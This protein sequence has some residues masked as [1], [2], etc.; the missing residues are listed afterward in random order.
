MQIN[1]YTLTVKYSSGIKHPHGNSAANHGIKTILINL[2]TQVM[3][4][5]CLN[6]CFQAAS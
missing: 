2:T 5:I 4:T 6:L 3:S 1:F